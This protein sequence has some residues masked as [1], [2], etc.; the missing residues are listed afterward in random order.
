MSAASLPSPTHRNA[1]APAAATPAITSALTPAPAT[2]AAA[3]PSVQFGPRIAAGLLGIFIA[4]MMASLNN[5]VGAIALTDV[6]GSLGFGLDDAS[7]L[8]TAYSAGELVAM[9]FA[10]WFAVT[11]TL[12]RFHL[13]MLAACGLIAVLLPFV[14]DLYLLLLLRGVQGLV[15]GTMIPL[16]MVAALR[17]M[18][19]S[20][21]LYALAL[22]AMTATCAPNIAIWLAGVWTDQIPDVRMVY[23]Q[24]LPAVSLAAALV[25]WGIPQDASRPERFG[26]ANWFGM[27]FGAIGLGLMAAAIDQGNR[28]EWFESDFVVCTLS[29]GIACT[30]VYLLSEWHHPAPFLKLQLLRRRNLGLSFSIFFCMLIVFLSGSLLPAA[31]LGN[32]WEYRA[33]QSAPIGLIIG[34]PQLFLAPFVAFLLY[35]KWVDARRLMALGLALVA[36]ACLQGAGLTS[37]WIWQEFIWAQILQAIGQPMAVV[38]MLFLATSVVQ[39]QEGPYVAGTVNALRAFGSVLGTGVVGRLLQ[40][41]ER[42][43]LEMMVD[44]IGRTGDSLAH[45]ENISTLAGA[46]SKQA[47]VLASADAY[48][49]LAVL[50]LLLIPCAL[51]LQYIPAPQ[52]RSTHQP[53]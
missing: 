28:L 5:R 25:A 24:V 48:R 18:P 13:M 2:P 35:R 34:L 50:A 15:T 49:V 36:V 47:S 26:Q 31:H 40:V 39:G 1:A 8:N 42:F 32:L 46:V 4:A 14:H 37:E 10:A 27:A 45:P 11:L 41:R 23:W 16:L 29:T 17:F 44:Y 22:Y 6:R 19:T 30:L 51:A 33:E 53:R 21:R 7:W 3:A 43:H 12:R 38:S 20:I 9:P 52:A